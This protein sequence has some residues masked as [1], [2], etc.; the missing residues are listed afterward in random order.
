[1]AI[2]G[3]KM[4]RGGRWS[5]SEALGELR[6]QGVIAVVWLPLSHFTWFSLVSLISPLIGCS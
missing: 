6:G 3:G 2:D 4:G 1:M 5:R